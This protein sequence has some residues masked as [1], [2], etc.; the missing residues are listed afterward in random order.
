MSHG[1]GRHDLAMDAIVASCYTTDSDDS[2][3]PQFHE[4]VSASPPM[5]RVVCRRAANAGRVRQYMA[6]W[7]PEED[8]VLLE[9]VM[10]HGTAEW[11]QLRVSGRLPLRDNKACCNRFLL[12]KSRFLL[13]KRQPLPTAQEVCYSRFLLLKRQPLPTAQEVC[14]SRFLLL[15]RYATAASYCSRDS[16]FLLLKRYATVAS[17]CS[18]GMLQPLPTAQE[19]AASYCSRGMLQPLPTAQEV[20]YSRFLLLK[21]YATAASCCSE[22]YPLVVSH[23]PLPRR[24]PHLPPPSCRKFLQHEQQFEQHQPQRQPPPETPSLRPP[25]H[26]LH[27]SARLRGLQPRHTAF[28]SSPCNLAGTTPAGVS[29]EASVGA[30]VKAIDSLHATAARQQQPHP[31]MLEQTPVWPMAAHGW[32]EDGAPWHGVMEPWLDNALIGPC[33]RYNAAGFECASERKHIKTA[34]AECH[35]QHGQEQWHA[36]MQQPQQQQ[37][38]Q[39]QQSQKQQQLHTQQQPQQKPED[40]MQFRRCSEQSVKTC[41]SSSSALSSWFRVSDP[42]SATTTSNAPPHLMPTAAPPS[43]APSPPAPTTSN[44]IAAQP[45]AQTT[46]QSAG[47]HHVPSALSPPSPLTVLLDTLPPLPPLSPLPA[48]PPL[49]LSPG[50]ELPAIPA[51]SPRPCNNAT[52]APP[53]VPL[54]PVPPP[55]AGADAATSVGADA[56]EGQREADLDRWILEQVGLMAGGQ[57]VSEQAIWA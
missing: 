9:H 2:R 31:R 13:L 46:L 7:T 28:H 38:L 25:Q 6:R 50:L 32:Q 12:L 27:P 36:F 56:L 55:L 39:P 45:A 47:Q 57:G 20:C 29:L 41:T 16:R 37:H 14:Y 11:G 18:R 19:T 21:R 34:G 40:S 51:S 22:S 1:G 24:A 48:L 33:V 26:P 17:Y 49:P 5:R 52:A 8:A 4:S 53:S 3:A 43:L 44:S 23:S 30:F 15:K 35:A 42:P 54:P 10:A